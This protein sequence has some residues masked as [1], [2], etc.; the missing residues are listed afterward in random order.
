MNNFHHDNNQFE[1]KYVEK[2]TRKK[3]QQAINNAPTV[4]FLFVEQS[5]KKSSSIYLPEVPDLKLILIQ[6]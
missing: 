3:I 2:M 4:L 1:S 6:K 5:R